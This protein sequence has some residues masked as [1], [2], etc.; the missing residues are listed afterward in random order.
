M[1]SDRI[2]GVALEKVRADQTSLD[3]QLTAL[4]QRIQAKRQEVSEHQRQSSLLQARREVLN[5]DLAVA[6]ERVRFMEQQGQTRS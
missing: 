2:Q 6:D 5:R 4:R 3:N 1:R